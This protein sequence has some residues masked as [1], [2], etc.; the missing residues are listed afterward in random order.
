MIVFLQDLSNYSSLAFEHKWQKKERERKRKHNG[1]RLSGGEI[2]AVGV[3][4]MFDGIDEN[5]FFFFLS[6]TCGDK[7]QATITAL[8]SSPPFP[9]VLENDGRGSF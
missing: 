2:A 8:P 3:K 4:V 9:P 7:F 6:A 1:C 5:L